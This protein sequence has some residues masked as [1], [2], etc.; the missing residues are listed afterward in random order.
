LKSIDQSINRSISVEHSVNTDTW[1]DT[2]FR[3]SVSY[4]LP[5]A[6]PLLSQVL[7][8]EEQTG[9]SNG[10]NIGHMI[11]ALHQLPNLARM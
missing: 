10:L 6:P 8:C 5:G 3:I 7:V 4:F 1:Y 2:Q 9:P 11:R